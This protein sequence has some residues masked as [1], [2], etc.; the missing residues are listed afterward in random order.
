[1]P[2]DPAAIDLPPVAGGRMRLELE[3][4]FVRIYN[5]ATAAYE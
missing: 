5:T 2:S 4:N 1:L 3:K